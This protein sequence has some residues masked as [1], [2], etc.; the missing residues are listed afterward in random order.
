[1]RKHPVVPEKS[2]N[3]SMNPE[4]IVVTVSPAPSRT[5]G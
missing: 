2:K 1:V 5:R 4:R 3:K